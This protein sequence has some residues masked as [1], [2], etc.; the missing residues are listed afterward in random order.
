MSKNLVIVESPAKAR[1][2]GRFLGKSYLAKASMGHIR[3]L[4]KKSMGVQVED[5]SFTP[6]YIL[7]PDRRKIIEELR[8]AVKQADTVY[9]ATD[10]DREGEA[11]SWH[12]IEAAKIEPNKVKRVVFHEIT[13]DAVEK[14]FENPREVDYNLV[15]AQQT[16]RI[17]DRLV[18]YELS[19]VLWKKVRPGLSAG[20]VQSLA[21]KLVIERET[22]HNNFVPKEYWNITAEVSKNNLETDT[23]KAKLTRIEGIKKELKLDN[24]QSTQKVLNDL[25]GASFNVDSITKKQ[26]IRKP[27][28][29]FIT[30]TLQ[31]DASRKFRFSASNTMRVAQ[32]LYEGLELGSEGLAGLITYMRTDSTNVA[33]S[34]LIETA[35]FIKKQ[36][37]DNYRLSKPRVYKRKVKGAQEAHEAIRP[38]SVFNTP[39]KIRK[40]LNNDQYNLYKLIWNRM[41]ASQMPDTVFDQTLVEIIA[42]TK[43]NKAYF[44]TAVGTLMKFDGYRTLYMESV[45]NSMESN[46]DKVKLPTLINGDLLNC[47]KISK[48]QNFTEAPPLYTEAALIKVLEDRGV[49]RPSTYAAIM[50]TIQDRYYIKKDNN[51]FVST[52]LGKV[53][54]KLL[55]QH[56]ADTLDVGFTAKLE[57]ELDE[58]ASGEREW[59]PVI[60][61]FYIPFH[62][63][64][65]KSDLEVERVSRSEIDEESSEVCE[66]CERPMV[67]K[68]G[69]Y[70]RFLSCSGFP[71]CKNARPLVSILDINCP[72]CS[73]NLV[74]KQRKGRSTKTFY[75][76]SN[77]PECNFATNRKPVPDPCPECNG[78]LVQWGQSRV[79]CFKCAYKGSINQDA[80]TS[81]QVETLA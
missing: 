63:L 72:K 64:I 22:D 44:F 52:K 68:L 56:F 45:D 48:E 11:I 1:T 31:Q 29:P 73:N 33:Q 62:N 26:K 79:R 59:I 12:L 2:V 40:Y 14:A 46:D 16:R 28:P 20:R 18:G 51:R 39:K 71:E 69:R 37:G 35:D 30:S 24:E 75:G 23:F 74:E 42:K 5:L 67:I 9:L 61:D 53:V 54:N 70:G 77:Y 3:D 21:V 80:T 55:T 17:L 6:K 36:Y 65:K 4:P 25:E 34:A 8:K 66:S 19:P 47:L 49:G 38:T 58:I 32:Q 13:K 81:E 27:P 7:I 10:P 43:I 15:A 78:L 76:C 41:V 60:K 50:G 57:V